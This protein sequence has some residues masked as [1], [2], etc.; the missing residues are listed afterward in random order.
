MKTLTN[1]QYAEYRQYQKTKRNVAVI[2]MYR[3]GAP[4][5][6]ISA[7]FGNMPI[8]TINSIRRAMN[9]PI[10]PQE[11]A[12]KHRHEGRLRYLQSRKEEEP[13][14]PSLSS[15]DAKLALICQKLG[16]EV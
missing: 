2:E 10:R 6:E 11:I 14:I 13:I 9:E 7:R 1:K 5:K 3:S 12:D 15:I 8:Q 16:I 4:Y